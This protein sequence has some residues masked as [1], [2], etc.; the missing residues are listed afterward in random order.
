MG[1]GGGGW[2]MGGEP[3]RLKGQD[4]DCPQFSILRLIQAWPAIYGAC[5]RPVQ[6]R[7]N[8]VF[9]V[10]SGTR[11][12]TQIWAPSPGTGTSSRGIVLGLCGAVIVLIC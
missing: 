1:E 9:S 3:W 2:G 8:I 7:L 10:G 12:K 11:T 5:A 6:S 4:V